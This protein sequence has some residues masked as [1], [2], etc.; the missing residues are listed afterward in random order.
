M[1]GIIERMAQLAGNAQ[2]H[3]CWQ[4]ERGLMPLHDGHLSK[5][6]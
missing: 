5:L 2:E 1:S 4:I 3:W 6:G